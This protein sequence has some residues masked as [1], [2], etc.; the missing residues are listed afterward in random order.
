M[1]MKKACLLVLSAISVGCAT[2]R[3]G[4]RPAAPVTTSEGG[5]PASR[6]P[7][8]PEAA[9]GEVYVTS[10]GTRDIDAGGDS[11][12]QLVHAR[13]A[14]ANQAG[15]GAWT[16]EPKEQLL[17]IPGGVPEAPSFMEIDGRHDGN[18]SVGRGER[19]VIDFYYRMPGGVRD[20]SQL[21]AFDLQWQV[22]TGG[23]VVAGR[24]SF[25]REI[26]RDYGESNRSTVA[27][28][29]VPP[30]WVYGFGPWWGGWYGP[31]GYPYYGPYLGFGFGFGIG[32]GGYHRGY[33]GG[34]RYG[35]GVGGGIG[36]GR[37]R[38]VVRGHPGR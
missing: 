17:I 15:E 2:D 22:N 30:W 35:G 36:G 3:Y 18:P 16:V 23:K 29:V 34:Q 20:A 4:F 14:V 19:K 12:S 11:R 5:F 10:F 32:G 33:Y 7:V 6:Y 26:Y 13:I 1:M 24:T 25:V 27:V 38:G 37:G 21:P 9:R 8:P 28:G 31:W